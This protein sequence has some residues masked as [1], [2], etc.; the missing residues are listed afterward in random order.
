LREYSDSKYEKYSNQK[1]SNSLRHYGSSNIKNSPDNW[2]SN[3]YRGNHSIQ[4]PMDLNVFDKIK[5]KVK[6]DQ[7]LIMNNIGYQSKSTR[8]S[9]KFGNKDFK[10]L[11]NNKYGKYILH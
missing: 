10:V 9:L 1:G 2:S 8:N 5:N 4:K 7:N 6:S 11:T 3:Y